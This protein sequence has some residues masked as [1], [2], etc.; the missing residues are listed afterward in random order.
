MQKNYSMEDAQKLIKANLKKRTGKSWSVICEPKSSGAW[1][2][3]NS[4]P[5]NRVKLDD[6]LN[7]VPLRK[8]EK[9]SCM[10][11]E[12]KKIL[13]KVMFMKVGKISLSFDVYMRGFIV[14]QT[15]CET[16]LIRVNKAECWGFDKVCWEWEYQ[17]NQPLVTKN[18]KVDEYAIDIEEIEIE[19]FKGMD[20]DIEIEETEVE[21][22]KQKPLIDLAREYLSR[23]TYVQTFDIMSQVLGFADTQKILKM[24]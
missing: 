11:F 17:S 4:L 24:V 20:T 22:N 21:E 7:Q 8:G 19:N 13:E 6:N 12:D 5:R 2:E 16:P 10:S 23:L 1:M 15:I 9:G 14:E 3:I 18:N